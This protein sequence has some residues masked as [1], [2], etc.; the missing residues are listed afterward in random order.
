MQADRKPGRAVLNG[1]WLSLVEHR[2]GRSAETQAWLEKATK[3][4]EQYPKGIPLAEDDAKGL[5]LHNWVEAQVLRREATALL[6]LK[7]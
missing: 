4:F 1:L 3:W 6:I 5:H 2:R 7:K